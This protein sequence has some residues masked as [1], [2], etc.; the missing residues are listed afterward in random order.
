[1]I[2]LT[3]E[4]KRHIWLFI[5]IYIVEMM[6]SLLAMFLMEMLMFLSWVLTLIMYLNN[7]MERLIHIHIGWL[8][9]QAQIDTFAF[10]NL[11]SFS[12]PQYVSG[13]C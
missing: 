5:F 13:V 12:L 3:D 8:F 2:P 10:M 6:I 1:M 9:A 11:L 7:I 4:V